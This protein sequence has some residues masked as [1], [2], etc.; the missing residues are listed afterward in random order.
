MGNIRKIAWEFITKPDRRF[1]YLARWGFLDSM[2][3]EEY[4]C[5]RFKIRVGYDL[6]LENPKTFNEKIQWIKLHDRDPK[7]CR[8]VDKY[9]AKKYVS[10]K[11]GEAYIIP[12]YGVWDHFNEIDFDTLP[13]QFVLKCTHDSE[14][15]VVVREKR[16]MDKAAIRRGLE[17][18]LRRNFYYKC[19]E[20]VYKDIPPRIIAE[21]Y[22][23]DDLDDAQKDS[24]DSSSKSIPKGLTDYK[25][26]C[27][28]GE[29]K[30][31][32]VSKGLED[33]HTARISF[34]NI[35]WTVSDIGRQDFR[36]FETLP[37]KPKHY[38]DMLDIAKRLS[39]GLRF[40]RV[41][42]YEI[43]GQIYF[44]ELTFTPGAGFTPFSSIDTDIRLGALLHIP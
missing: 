32:Y 8:M 5:R 11:I 16:T 9:E 20:W 3:D 38:D 14:S 29:P 19:R 31:L 4:L 24:P 12:T 13:E 36:P 35:D 10:E 42:L 43:Q 27:F 37:E 15:V 17:K 25:F 22:M 30:Y 7:Y 26:Y 41:D 44:G 2:P 28:H 23:S 39:A 18:S 33:Q 34:L 6:N 21:K 1:I 40:V